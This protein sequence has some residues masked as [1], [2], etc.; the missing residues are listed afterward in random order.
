MS[1][2]TK[3]DKTKKRI[4]KKNDKVVK[5]TKIEKNDKV[6]LDTSKIEKK[7]NFGEEGKFVNNLFN[8]I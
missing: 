2:V 1:D 6:I 3:K 5:T 7:I 4:V 8:E